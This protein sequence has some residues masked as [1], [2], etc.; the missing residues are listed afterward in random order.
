G[1]ATAI[2]LQPTGSGKAAATGDFVMTG[3]EVAGVLRALRENGIEVTALHSHMVGE[4][5]RLYFAHFW[6]NADATQVARGLAA[7]LARMA[8]R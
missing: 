8:V 2:N 3:N 7:A 4:E 5:P 6:A 1:V